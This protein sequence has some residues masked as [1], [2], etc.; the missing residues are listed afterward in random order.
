MRPGTIGI[1]GLLLLVTAATLGPLLWMVSGSLKTQAEL[2]EPGLG[3]L[4]PVP[5]TLQNYRILFA[6][7]PFATFFV[8]TVCV[9]CLTALVTTLVS[10]LGGY[11]LAKYSFR[12]KTLVTAV[13]LGTMLLPAVV[14]LAPLFRV[15]CAL[16]LI[17]T[18]WGLVLPGAAS[19]FGVLIMRQY[20]GSIPGDLLDAGRLDGASELGIFWRVVLPLVRPITSAL[21]IFT[22]LGSWN[23]YLWPMIVLRDERNYTLTVAVTN[24]VASIHQQEYGVILGGTLVSI[25]PIILLFLAL[26]R[27]FIAGLTL[28]AVKQ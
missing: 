23:A 1:Y 20:L 2:M 25:A 17:D 10:A 19:G 11:A 21:L 18:F 4:V 22:F 12:G 28:G 8:N 26:Q 7:V 13:V 24:V 5:A 16:R 15:V 14:L 3:Q 9:A 27:E 6:R